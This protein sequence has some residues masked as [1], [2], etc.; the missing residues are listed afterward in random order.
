[1]GTQILDDGWVWHPVGN[2]VTWSLERWLSENVWES[3]DG[4]SRRDICARAYYWDKAL[5]WLDEK[6]V[7]IGGIGDDE[8]EIIAGARIFDITRV[9]DPGPQWRHDWPWALEL[10]AFPGPTGEFF[11]D[12][13]SLYSSDAR[14]LSR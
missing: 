10:T 8:Q 7:A 12:G 1:M 11:S 2:P 9:G 4:P 14:G 3:E 6:R 13:T 5:I